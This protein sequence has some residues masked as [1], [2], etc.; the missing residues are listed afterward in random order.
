MQGQHSSQSSFFGLIY[1]DLTPQDHLL[2]RIARAVDFG[3]VRELMADCYCPGNGR[4][5]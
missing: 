4:P 5:S 2:Q 1:E 3:F